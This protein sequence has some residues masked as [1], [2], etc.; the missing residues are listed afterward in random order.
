M[1]SLGRAA[2]AVGKAKSTI[3][4]DVKIGRISAT[5]NP[6][7]SWAIDPAELHRVYPAAA[8]ANGSTNLQ[9]NDLQPL[10]TGTGMAVMRRE[11]E[12]LREQL[13]D[14]DGTIRDLRGRLDASETERRTG[15]EERRRTQT[16]LTA[17]LNDR[18]EPP[19]AD[20]PAS[21]RWRRRVLGWIVRQHV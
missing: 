14:R 7:G 6:D 16:Q 11:I 19:A 17:L 20:P 12:L 8:A 15:D 18:R 2:R 13:A 5:R 10:R 9:S 3:S 1:Y 4:R 21:R